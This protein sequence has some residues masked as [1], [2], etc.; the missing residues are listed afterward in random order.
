MISAFFAADF[1]KH[2]APAL[3]LT[4]DLG[5]SIPPALPI[6]LRFTSTEVY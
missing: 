5:T 4:V 3:G 2:E 1:T 6:A